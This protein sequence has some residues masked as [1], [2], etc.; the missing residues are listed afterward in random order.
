MDICNNFIYLPWA[1]H[2]SA[3]SS[4][5]G[6]AKSGQPV[7][8]GFTQRRLSEAQ[9]GVPDARC[10]LPPRACTVRYKLQRLSK[11]AQVTSDIKCGL[12]LLLSHELI[13]HRIKFN[14][15]L[16][17]NRQKNYPPYL[18][19]NTNRINNFQLWIE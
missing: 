7:S 6:A 8:E 4:T 16:G 2:R 3:H 14:E 11:S 9:S 13:W 15:I 1:G 18:A 19:P 12:A 10:Q 5:L 17:Q